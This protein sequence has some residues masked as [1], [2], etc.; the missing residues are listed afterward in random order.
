M[1]ELTYK[2]GRYKSQ[3]NHFIENKMKIQLALLAILYTFSS[4]FAQV[5]T[6]KWQSQ[7]IVIDGSGSDWG[8]LPRFFN[9]ESNVK[10]EFRN[11]A[12]NLYIILKAAELSTQ[13]QLQRAGF[14]VKLKVKTSPQRK[15]GITFAASKMST[16][17]NNQDKLVDKGFSGIESIPKDSAM[18][19]GFQ[20]TNGKIISENQD[21]KSICFARS[22]SNKELTTY[23]LR[24]PLREIFGNEYVLE[25]ITAATIQLQVAMNDLSLNDIR[26]SKTRVNG[27]GYGGGMD[28]GGGRGMGG[29]MRGERGMN[30]SGEMDGG[31]SEIG[32]VPGSEMQNRMQGQ[33]GF[34][35]QRKSFNIDF[36]LSTGK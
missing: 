29:G 35:M 30:N 23:E 20:F 21:Q 9:A 13:M 4:A 32:E 27:G 17:Q 28:N 3:Y 19:D 26:K 31:T 5:S 24:I 33:S 18:L 10:Y 15:V 7:P 14:S 34:S 25:T 6:S 16:L 36:K 12:Q 8:T 22:K 1:N 2:S 11:D